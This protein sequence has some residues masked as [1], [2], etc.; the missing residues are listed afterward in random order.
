MCGGR[1]FQRYDDECAR[2]YNDRFVGK[3]TRA[4]SSCTERRA[5]AIV[6][7]LLRVFIKEHICEQ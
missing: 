4:L 6:R 3:S 1:F 2:E 7:N 5:G